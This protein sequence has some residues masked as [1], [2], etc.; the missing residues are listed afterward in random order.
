M[1]TKQFIK[2]AMKCK[3]ISEMKLSMLLDKLEA[4]SNDVENDCADLD[5]AKD[6]RNVANYLK[7]QTQTL[8][9]EEEQDDC[10][11][12]VVQVLIKGD[13]YEIACPDNEDVWYDYDDIS[14]STNQEDLERMIGE[15]KLQLLKDG[16][17]D[18]VVMRGD[19]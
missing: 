10:I 14:C 6:I 4:I 3:A 19:W 1:A 2:S 13:D 17:I 18:Y 9:I 12:N 11:Y 5:L 16:K 8:E 15:H 7:E